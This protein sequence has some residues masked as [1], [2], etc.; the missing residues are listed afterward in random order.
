[1]KTKNFFII[2]V[3]EPK[4]NT[5]LHMRLIICMMQNFDW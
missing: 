1:L 4:Y 5:V 3:F 2:T